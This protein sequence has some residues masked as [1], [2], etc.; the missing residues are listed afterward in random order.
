MAESEGFE[1]PIA[2]RLCLISSQVHSTGLCHLSDWMGYAS[3]IA[4]G[5]PVVL[6][7]VYIRAN[8]SLS[9]VVSL[10]QR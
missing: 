5:A 7:P 6:D 3:I 1:P 10:L 2:L 4:Q 8:P 9:G